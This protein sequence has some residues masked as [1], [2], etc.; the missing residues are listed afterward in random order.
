MAPERVVRGDMV[1]WW[2]VEVMHI[3][4][5]DGSHAITRAMQA[6]MTLFF[7]LAARN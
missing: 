5:F 2:G 1:I 3:C 6:D 4:E 7:L